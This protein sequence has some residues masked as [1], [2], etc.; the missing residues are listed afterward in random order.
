MIEAKL[1]LNKQSSAQVQRK[2]KQLQKSTGDMSLPNRSV[3]LW[4]LRWVNENFKSQGGKV[5]GWKPF[6]IGGRWIGKG[7]NRKLDTSA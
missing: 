1:V 7:L 2:F 5:G 6:K 4:L 3:S